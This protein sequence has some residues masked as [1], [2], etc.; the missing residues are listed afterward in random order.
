MRCIRYFTLRREN[1]VGYCARWEMLAMQLS[2]SHGNHTIS[3]SSTRLQ[4]S[5]GAW[6]VHHKVWPTA[7]RTQLFF[8][9]GRYHAIIRTFCWYEEISCYEQPMKTFKY[10]LFNCMEQAVYTT[11]NQRVER[12]SDCMLCPGTTELTNVWAI[13]CATPELN[14]DITLCHTRGGKLGKAMEYFETFL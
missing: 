11:C 10:L 12:P 5:S 13:A 6:G 9:P 1:A 2:L 7:I 14:L 8:W 3:C 4:S